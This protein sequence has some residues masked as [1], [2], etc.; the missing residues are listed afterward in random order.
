M[1]PAER[2]YGDMLAEKLTAVPYVPP[3]APPPPIETPWGPVG[4]LG[5]M[6]LN[7]GC[8]ERRA[9]DGAAIEFP[10]LDSMIQ[11]HQ[12]IPDGR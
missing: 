10:D 4:N 2:L 6:I 3:P 5:E 8:R 7:W 11:F 9:H 12:P 1:T